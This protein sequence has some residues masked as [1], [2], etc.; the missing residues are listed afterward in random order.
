M[1][2]PCSLAEW[3]T[4]CGREPS[5]RVGVVLPADEM[6]SLR[7]DLPPAPYDLLVD[8]RPVGR[9]R[10]RAAELHVG[11]RGVQ[12]RDDGGQTVA[13][14]ETLRLVA[15]A[16][17]PVQ[18]GSGVRLHDVVTGRGFHWQKRVGFTF[19]GVLEFRAVAGRLLVVNELGLEDYLQ[20]VITAE[21]SGRCPIEFLKT[22]CIVARS[23]VLAHT[24]PKH[25]DLPIDRCNDDC[26]Q[27]YQGTTSW[28]PSAAE[29]VIATRGQVVTDAAG[30]IIDA[31]YSKSCGGIIEAPEYVWFTPKTCQRAAVDAPVD[32]P[33]RRFLPVI[34]DNLDDFLGGGWLAGADVF[35][36][37][38][39]VPDRD[40]PRY[41]G[42]VDEGGGHFRWTVT[43]SRDQLENV[44]RRKLARV[45]AEPG[46]PASV[47]AGRI[48]VADLPPREV[49]CRVPAIAR[50]SD[51][52][53]VQRGPS[54]RACELEI[55]YEDRAGRRCR[56]G[57]RSEY[58]I[59]EVLHE[60]FLYSSAFKVSIERGGD[61]TPAAIS[62]IGAGWGHGAG[63]CQIGALGMAVRGYSCRDILT[64][65]F[66]GVEIRALY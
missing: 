53:V 48:L 31:N 8:G 30:H 51:L 52:R 56:V 45:F 37:P 54:G 40:L 3:H 55:E 23:W 63:M 59:R 5:I 39:I 66:A 42:S 15:A 22:Q 36:S 47:E 6:R 27:R 46:E 26:C 29:A 57:I 43:Y 4:D 61:G 13:A 9:M 60:K 50:L 18:Q 58:R 62:L 7:I 49:A 19:E 38:N 64:H 44:L 34:E 12:W 1:T 2:A 28:T 14:G 21:M 41:L 32:S 24:E 16:P 65:Y 10:D 17:A 33:C 11:Q 20:G 35:C 25:T